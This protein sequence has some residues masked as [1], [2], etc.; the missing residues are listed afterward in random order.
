MTR[1]ILLLT[2][3]LCLSAL[4]AQT[5]KDI[6]NLIQNE[7]RQAATRLT[8]RANPL[9]ET[10]DLKYHRLE[11]F[12]NPEVY[13]IRGAVTSYF[14]AVRDGLQEIVFELSDS[15]RVDSLRYRGQL[16]GSSRPGNDLLAI[17]LP[18]ALPAGTFDSLTVY[19]QGEPPRTGFGSFSQTFHAGTPIIWTLSEPYG[20]KDWWPCKQTLNDKIDSIDVQVTTP[21]VYRVASNGLLVEE[22]LLGDFTRYHWRHRYPIPAYLIAIGVTNYAVY[23]QSIPTDSGAIPLVN[24]V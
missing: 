13:Y 21:N 4:R 19:Y 1:L 20:A 7:R 12:V 5:D 22:K 10:Y 3:L 2:A 23:E 15:L 11:W 6:A 18:A 14:T 8:F 17:D 9:T 24:Y 16:I